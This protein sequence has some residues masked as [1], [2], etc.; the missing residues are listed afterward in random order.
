MKKYNNYLTLI[1]L[2]VT[3]ICA[4]DNTMPEMSD[5]YLNNRE[6]AINPT[7]EIRNTIIVDQFGGGDYT[8]IQDAIDATDEGDAIIQVNAGEYYE[9]VYIHQYNGHRELRGAGMGATIMK[10]LCNPMFIYTN[11]P[12][13]SFIISG[14]TY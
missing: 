11:G 7:H 5:E 9:N 13:S 6:T 8:T 4:Q 2:S 1:A 14:F 12:N 10:A 3:L